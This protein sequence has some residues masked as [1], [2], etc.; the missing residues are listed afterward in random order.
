MSKTPENEEWW[1]CES[2]PHLAMNHRSAGDIGRYVGGDCAVCGFYDSACKWI[3]MRT[4]I[5]S[6]MPQ[7]AHDIVEAIRDP[8]AEPGHH[9]YVMRK[10]AASW[11]SLWNALQALLTEY[12]EHYA[13]SVRN[14]KAEA[15]SRS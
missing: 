5:S 15:R 8:G 7:T 11:P 9:R 3:N 14:E 1:W 4:I 13:C 12:D 2:H 10:T 6:S